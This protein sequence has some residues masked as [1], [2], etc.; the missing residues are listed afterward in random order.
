MQK[1]N[2]SYAPPDVPDSIKSFDG[3]IRQ[4]EVGKAGKDGAL[5]LVFESRAGKTVLADQFAKVPLY[6]Q[7]ALYYDGAAPGLAYVYMLSASGGVLQGDRYKID[8]KLKRGSMAHI[9]TQGATRIYSMDSNRA[10]QVINITLERDSYL[11]WVPDQIIPY[12]NSRFYQETSLNVHDSATL[13]YSEIITPGRMAMGER[14]EY[15]VLYVKT[16]AANQDGALRLAD[17][18]N[19]E[20]K[21]RS[22][23]EFGILGNYSVAGTVYILTGRQNVPELLRQIRGGVCAKQVACG[24]STTMR[25]DGLVV[26]I[27]GSETEAVKDA[28]FEVVKHARKTCIDSSFL[29]VRKS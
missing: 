18:A 15:D 25:D 12:R 17:A 14:F 4:L 29:G 19:L 1:N 9:T 22:P 16:R 3:K 6:A 24:A 7:R 26:R 28:V 21:R 23:A 8:V 20:P 5:R 2:H 27:L 11:E 10:T 13:V